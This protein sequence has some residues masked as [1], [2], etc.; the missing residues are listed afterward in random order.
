MREYPGTHYPPAYLVGRRLHRRQVAHNRMPVPTSAGTVGRQAGWDGPTGHELSFELSVVTLTTHHQTP[1]L[2]S[3]PIPIPVHPPGL[4]SCSLFF[5]FSSLLHLLPTLSFDFTCFRQT[6]A[7]I[8]TIGTMSEPDQ[9]IICLDHLPTPANNINNGTSSDDSVPLALKT[10]LREP[11]DSYLNIVAALDGCEHII[12]DTCIR[13]WAQK[14]NTCP[15]C[16]TP[17]HSVRVY[18]GL[19]VKDKKQV[20]E[21]D[22]QQWLGDNAEEEDEVSNPCPVCNSAERE[23][24]LLLC[25]SCDAAYHTHCLGLDHIPDGDWYCMECAHAFELTEESQNGSQPVDSEAPQ[26][27][28]R[29]VRRPAARQHRGLHVRTRAR[30]RRARRQARNAEWQG[31]WGQF[32]G[33]F[34]EMSDLDLDNL[35]GEDEDLENF[36]RF[37]QLDLHE[38]QRWQQ[39]M[40]IANR[41]GAHDAFVST[42]PPQISERLQPVATPPPP[43]PIQETRDERRA[44]GA[45]DMAR[46]AEGAPTPGN[47]RKRKATSSIASPAEPIPEPERKLKRPRTRRLPTHVEP[48][49]SA[50]SPAAAGPSNQQQ[51]RPGI[52]T[53]PVHGSPSRAGQLQLTPIEPAL[54]SALLKE[55]E[56]SAQSEDENG[57][58]LPMRQMPD[59]S[60][61]AISPST[62]NH[63]SPRAMCL[64]PP[65][66]PRLNGRPT[67]PTLSLST[68]IEPV[69]APAN[70]SPNRYSS[71]HSDSESRL[72]RAEA[73]RTVEIRQP[74]PRRPQTTIARTPDSSPTR[75]TMTQE[76]KRSI[77]DIVK[78]ALRPHWRAQKLTTEQYATIN[79]DISRR[80][81]E[82]VKG[83]SVLDQATRRRWEQKADKAV[84][85]AISDLTAA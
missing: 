40:S 71:D 17:F 72:A 74:R 66:L 48:S 61:P 12:H 46:E 54:V 2:A 18:N 60:S 11:D 59:A 3:I 14:T 36:R 30:W 53:A 52:D 39:R 83:A 1:L 68:H 77:N 64:T 16:R 15:I 34:Y 70:Y 33:R 25:D 38:L 24:I 51:T 7:R 6:R 45:L 19:D 82:E 85:Q 47:A 37:Q 62:S 42:I 63:S 84:A 78:S 32:S 81:Y 44:W 41:L 73:I 75:L 80:L 65:P 23:D 58:A 43:P 5:L 20:A 29:L 13:S 56:P 27:H 9:C 69:Y 26:P 50:P 4:V 8:V 10:Q 35:D 49:T 57:V 22:V 79:R 76:D 28:P 31:P 55:L 21:F 67:S